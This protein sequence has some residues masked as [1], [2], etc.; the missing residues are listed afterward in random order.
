MGSPRRLTDESKRDAAAY[1]NAHRREVSQVQAAANL[2]ISLSAFSR[3]LKNPLYGGGNANAAATGGLAAGGLE[4]EVR[5]LR[6]EDAC[7]K[8]EREILKKAAAFFADEEAAQR[9]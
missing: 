4:A 1:Y 9:K 3:W 6:K 5:R 8:R 7:L 2:G